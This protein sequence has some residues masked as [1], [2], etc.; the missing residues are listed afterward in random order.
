MQRKCHVTP[1]TIPACAAC[2]H[3]RKKCSE[4]CTLAP[5]FP[6]ERNREFQAVHKVFGVSNV[7]KM[8]KNANEANRRK[9]VDSLVWEALCRQK[10]PVLGPYGEYRMIFDELKTYKSHENQTV[11]LQV[12]KG[13]C[14]K[15]LTDLVAWNY[16]TNGISNGMNGGNGIATTDSLDYDLQVNENMRIDSVPPYG[17]PLSCEQE[18]ASEK[19]KQV[20]MAAD[21]IVVPVVHQQGHSINNINQQ[22]YISGQLNQI[23]GKPLERTIWE[24]GS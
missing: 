14:Y 6:V 12:Q 4:G 16:E 11:P 1:G 13:M 7:T 24:G 8:V 19:I 3:Q 23:I 2:K 17:Y 10:D 21:S 18:I 20:K 22:Y 9:V 15:S 5:Y